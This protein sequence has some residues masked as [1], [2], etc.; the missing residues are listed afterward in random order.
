MRR[1]ADWEAGDTAALDTRATRRHR[2][3][4]N[5]T[6]QAGASW[7]GGCQGALVAADGLQ[8]LFIVD[9]EHHS[10]PDSAMAHGQFL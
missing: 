1:P 7:M 9:P 2:V 10:V 8:H 6:N 3:P 5:R 4:L